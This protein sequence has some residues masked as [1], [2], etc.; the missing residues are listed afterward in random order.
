MRR[1]LVDLARSRGSL[2]RGG[3]AY[4]IEFDESWQVGPGL[5]RDLVGLDDALTE[6]A[7]IDSAK[8]E[9]D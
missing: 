7:R 6:L 9:G 5:P 1:I 2:K 4:R 8:G 3:G